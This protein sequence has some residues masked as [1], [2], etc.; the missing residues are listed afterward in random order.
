MEE[1]DLNYIKVRIFVLYLQQDPLL[2]LLDD[3]CGRA[4]DS[5]QP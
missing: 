1:K 2:N 4:I 3:Q 5:Q